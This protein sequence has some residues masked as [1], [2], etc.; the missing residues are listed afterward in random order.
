[1]K[2]LHP[3]M[4]HE[5]WLV[6]GVNFLIYLVALF[7]FKHFWHVT[8]DSR[9]TSLVEPWN[10]EQLRD[11][12][13]ILGYALFT[14]SSLILIT[15]DEVTPDL[16]VMAFVFL[17][18]GV[19]LRIQSGDAS[20]Q[21]YTVLGVALG[22]AYLAKAAMFPLGVVFLAVATFVSGNLRKSATRLLLATMLFVAISGPWIA[23]LSRAAGHLTF[24]ES[25]GLNYAWQVSG[26]VQYSPHP[27]GFNLPHPVQKVYD[28]PAVYQFRGP[29]RGSYPFWSDPSYWLAGV[30]AHFRLDGQIHSLTAN[31]GRLLTFPGQFVWAGIC[32][33]LFLITS[34]LQILPATVLKASSLLV[35]SIAA[36]AMYALVHLETRYVAAYLV[37][38]W[39]GFLLIVA[40]DTT[41]HLRKI[42]LP[43]STSVAVVLVF[44]VLVNST[45]TMM[46]RRALGLDGQQ[47]LHAA[48]MLRQIGL[49][50][51]DQ[52][53]SVGDT[54]SAYYLRL[55]RLTAISEITV[56]DAP[57]FWAAGPATQAQVIEA[58]RRTGARAIVAENA[59]APEASSGWQ[60]LGN[61]KYY[62]Y[63][64]Q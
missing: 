34:R 12:W 60:Q 28:V 26:V 6:H 52:V 63:Q 25:A 14:W 7:A 39:T 55:A 20:V 51:G 8:R 30:R 9:G 36:I 16:L 40:G 11:A 43:L 5:F 31:L 56:E 62:V 10:Q 22:L 48:V 17:A 15:L 45:V 49:R 46:K 38:L 21:R 59:P 61:T 41:L 4:E 50:P 37:L 3:S 53:A 58:F 18:A 47:D 42:L 54:F 64:L 1:M 35:P 23:A 33:F 27:N 29:V 57:R 13:T 2:L 19:V 44:C 32:L 24:G